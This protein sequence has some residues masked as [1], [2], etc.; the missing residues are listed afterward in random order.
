MNA[1]KTSRVY[2]CKTQVMSFIKTLSE[3]EATGDAAALYREDGNRLGYVA[4]YTKAFSHRPD[5][6]RGWQQL[7]GAIKSSMDLRIYE[8][9]TLA[10]A[11]RLRSSYCSLA[12]GKVLA[13]KFYSTTE[14][15]SIAR[16]YTDAGLSESE[17]AL[18]AFAEKVATRAN[19][20]TVSDIDELRTH[21]FSDPEIF[22]IA[23]A[24]AARC[25]FSKLLDAMGAEPDASYRELD[26]ELLSILTVGRSIEE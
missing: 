18:M 9:A 12:H 15:A 7:N 20:I 26:P 22:D 2:E 11:T 23:A 6:L 16:D 14:V 1:I 8:L 17:V 13:S 25:F 19:E 24:A 3:G 4:N 21:G 5:V 10:A